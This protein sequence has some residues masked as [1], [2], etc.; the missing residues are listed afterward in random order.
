MAQIELSPPLGKKLEGI[1]AAP[2][3]FEAGMEQQLIMQHIGQVTLPLL[4]LVCWYK[5]VEE[6]LRAMISDVL[7]CSSIKTSE[8]RECCMSNVR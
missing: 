6:K 3:L 5:R 8:T 2:G 1:S 4:E 7:T